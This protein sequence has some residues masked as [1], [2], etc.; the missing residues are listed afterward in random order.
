MER[1]WRNLCF[2]TRTQSV[3]LLGQLSGLS[4]EQAQQRSMS[5]ILTMKTCSIV[6]FIWIRRARLILQAQG[7][8]WQNWS[9]F[10]AQDQLKKYQNRIRDTQQ[11]NNASGIDA[12]EMI[13]HNLCF[14]IMPPLKQGYGGFMS[15]LRQRFLLKIAPVRGEVVHLEEALQNNF[16]PA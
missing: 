3:C 5:F 6:N 12:I 2:C 16:G 13:W 4:E 7:I 10:F 14:T 15:D 9:I 1:I 11:D 8:H